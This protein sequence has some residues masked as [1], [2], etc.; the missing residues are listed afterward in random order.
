MK[1]LYREVVYDRKT[2]RNNEMLAL[3]SG[4]PRRK[5]RVESYRKREHQRDID[6]AVQF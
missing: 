4:I 6:A 1:V 3:S 2:Y 5:D